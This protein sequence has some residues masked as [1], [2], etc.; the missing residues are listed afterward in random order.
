MAEFLKN[1]P[2]WFR[3][4]LIFPLI[5]LNFWLL[6]KVTGYFQPL[7]NNIITATLL[8]FVI[9]FPISFLQRNKFPGYGAKLLVIL[10]VLVFFFVL[11]VTI[12][13]SVIK[14]LTDLVDNLPEWIQSANQNLELLE[15]WLQTK[16]L[17]VDFGSLLLKLTQKL[18]TQLQAYSQELLTLVLGTF[19]SLLNIFFILVL[20]IFLVF[21]GEKVW[22]GIFSWLPQPWNKHLSEL[23]NSTFTNYFATQAILAFILS[24]IQTSVFFVLGIPYSLLFGV[25]IG[26]STLIPYASALIIIVISLLIT[27][28]DFYLG[29]KLLASTIIVSQIN[30]NLIAP[31]LMGNIIGLNP[32]WLIVVLVIGGKLGGILGLL[33]AVPVGS[34]IKTLADNLRDGDISDSQDIILK[35]A[36]N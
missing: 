31:R 22:N 23:I 13:P 11:A 19:N 1:L 18:S 29:L 32:F 12:I 28:Q 9:N 20:T 15:N 33:L 10:T 25:T 30:D 4:L 5:F 35:E 7:V 14:E 36:D 17:P 3:L 27:F 6:F 2:P 21:T 26:L 16:N 24:I 34:V 8:A